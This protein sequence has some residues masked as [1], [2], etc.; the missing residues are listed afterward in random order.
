MDAFLAEGE[1]I[2]QTLIMNIIK[3]SQ[4]DI[5]QIHDFCD[6]HREVLD[7]PKRVIAKYSIKRLINYEGN[8]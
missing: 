1:I 3:Y 8:E 5:L 7:L 4:D 6:L 2:I